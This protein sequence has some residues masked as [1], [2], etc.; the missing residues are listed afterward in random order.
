MFQNTMRQTTQ[1]A[2]SAFNYPMRHHLN[3]LFQMLRH[4]RLNEV[5]VTDNHFTSDK[6]VLLW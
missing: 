6:S 3:S 2:K 1:L 5:I 4:K